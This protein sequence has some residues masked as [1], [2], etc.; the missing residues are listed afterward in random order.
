MTRNQRIQLI[1]NA[2]LR[3]DQCCLWEIDRSPDLSDTCTYTLEGQTKK[4]TIIEDNCRHH[5]LPHF[6]ST[7]FV[8]L[9]PVLPRIRVASAAL[10]YSLCKHPWDILLYVKCNRFLRRTDKTTAADFLLFKSS[11]FFFLFINIHI[12]YSE[13]F[14]IDSNFKNVLDIN[15][16]YIWDTASSEGSV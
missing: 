6:P 14:C 3:I 9:G 15:S 7:L 5:C 10:I 12:A 1:Y 4:L 8:H 16:F 13:Y 11:L 2:F